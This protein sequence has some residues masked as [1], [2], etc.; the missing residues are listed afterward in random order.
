MGFDRRPSPPWEILKVVGITIK[1]EGKGIN[2]EMTVDGA[3]KLARAIQEGEK[4]GLADW[5]LSELI[6]VGR[7]A[8]RTAAPPQTP[9]LVMIEVGGGNTQAFQGE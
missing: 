9:G 5:F 7:Q 8:R 2:V 6:R 1:P 4:G 3:A